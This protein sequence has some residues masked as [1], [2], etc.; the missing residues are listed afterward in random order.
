MVQLE[1]TDDILRIHFS[2]HDALD[3]GELSLFFELSLPT[4]PEINTGMYVYKS[5]IALPELICEIISLLKT[6]SIEYECNA[7]AES[8][9]LTRSSE[10]RDFERTIEAGRKLGTSK[11]PTFVPTQSFV[12]ILKP[13]QLSAAQHLHEI[14]NS[15]NFSVPG[16]GKTS[17]VYAVYSRMIESRSIDRLM[18]IG[19]RSSFMSWEDEY[20]GCFNSSP[21]S[22][23]V[24]GTSI[25]RSRAYFSKEHHDIL[26]TT[27]Q[28][29]AKDIRAISTYLNLHK[30]FLVLDESHYIKRLFGGQW[31][32]ALLRLAPLATKRAILTGTPMPN[33]VEDLWNQFE[34]LWPGRRILGT[35]DNFHT[36]GKFDQT[37]VRDS[38]AP[39]FVRVTKS[40]LNLPIPHLKSFNVP[41]AEYQQKIYSTILARVHAEWR[42]DPTQRAELRG[43]R[44]ARI[45]RLLQIASNPALLS[46]HSME[47]DVP[48]L[49][50]EDQSVLDLI[51]KYPK[52]ETPAKVQLLDKLI[53]QIVVKRSEKV[54]VWTNFVHNITMF[55]KRYAH[56]N[57][58]PMYGEIARDAKEDAEDNRETYLKL[59]KT[60]PDNNLLI[61]NP[62]TCAESVSLHKICKHAIYYDRTFNCGQFLQSM[63]RIHRVGLSPKDEVFFYFLL[64]ENSI[65]SVIHSRLIQKSQV[66]ERTLDDDIPVFSYD[67]DP[68]MLG[69]AEDQADFE[70]FL[71]H[72]TAQ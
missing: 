33:D 38:I 13:F 25:S 58:L 51:R 54:I 28:S 40:K 48:P 57:P 53:K 60:H 29:A 50:G 5:A 63:D 8:L 22:L 18:V 32:D 15:A 55:C 62:A 66:M 44:K 37:F 14:Q 49:S 64:S 2:K 17:V 35:K 36:R 45:V 56:L 26:L 21:I 10:D 31:A 20:Y 47:F 39:F 16:S 71:S 7:R 42:L 9:A 65:D 24:V 69:D 43:W 4:K 19:P 34:F 72:I 68:T 59:F 27:Y 46:K 67:G 70:S 30:V 23:R 52:F 41:M 3:Q 1:V 6:R 12:R 61:A 11:S